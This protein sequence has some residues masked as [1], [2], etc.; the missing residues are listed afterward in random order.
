[1]RPGRGVTTHTPITDANQPSSQPSSM[2]PPPDDA[3]GA[4][5]IVSVVLVVA[6]WPVLSVTLR[7]TVTVPVPLVANVA[8]A[9]LV[10]PLKLA[11]A[12]PL[13]MAHW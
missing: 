4:A 8:A 5:A 13:V 9:P 1:M 2:A 12:A 7:L 6:L 11:I 3:G 10:A